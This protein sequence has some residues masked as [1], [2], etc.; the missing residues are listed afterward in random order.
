MK[1]LILG[2]TLGVLVVGGVL[3]AQPIPVTIYDIQYTTDPSGDSPLVG[4][5]VATGIVTGIFGNNFFIE[6]Q[7]GGAWHGVF[8]Y[9]ASISSPALSIGDSVEVTGTVQEYNKMTEI[10]A[11]Q[12]GN[13]VVLATG[14]PLPETT[15]I[16]V[17]DLRDEESY[18]GVLVRLNTVHFVESGTF[19]ASHSYHIVSS[20]NLDTA[21]VF[22]KSQTNIPG[23][24]IPAEDCDLVGCGAQWH[25][26]HEL[27]PRS[28]DDIIT[29]ENL[30]PAIG[31]VFRNPYTPSSSESVFFESEITDQDGTISQALLYYSTDGGGS[32]NTVGTDSTSGDLYYFS[33]G[34]LSNGTTVLYYVYAQDNEGAE[35]ISDTG[36]YI[37]ATVPPVKINEVLYDA[38]GQTEPYAEWVE[39][40]NAGDTEVDLSDWTFADDPNPSDISGSFDGYFVFPSGTTLGAHEFLILCYDADTFNYYWP[41]HGS[42]QVIEY[43]YVPTSDSLFIGNSGSDLH[44]FDSNLI[45]VDVM[46]YGSGGDLYYMGHAAEDVFAGHSLIRV[47]DGADTDDPSVDFFDSDTT[48]PGPTPGTTNQPQ[49]YICGDVNCS[50]GVGYDDLTYLA[51]YLFGGGPAPCSMWAADVNCSGSVAYDDLTYLASYLF[52]GGPAPDCC[53]Q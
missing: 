19:S 47:P 45:P 7:P 44:L 36:S 52:G 46:W 3:N 21:V 43:G 51:S 50:G 24:P 23:T 8:V 35:T 26:T 1:K 2:L 25:S 27:Y 15:V 16:T 33:L 12:E 20:D 30:P 22:I 29:Y 48:D 5:E 6:E 9:R 31:Y 17:A 14:V 53:P 39:I 11:T 28:T 41:D 10:Q 32:W 4:T 18:E 38:A 13:V 49:Q 40:Y 34:A 37:V 42:A